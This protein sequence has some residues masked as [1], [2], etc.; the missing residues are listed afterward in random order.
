MKKEDNKKVRYSKKVVIFTSALFLG[1]LIFCLTRDYT[2]F[3]DVSIY[4]SALTITGGIMGTSVLW[5]MKKT[6]AEHVT[7]TQSLMYENVMKMRLEYN[8]QM[9]ELKKQ[10]KMED[11]EVEQIEM[12]SPMDDFSESV[13]SN[14]EANISQHMNEA[15]TSIEM[16]NY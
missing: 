15:T 6:Q 8:K 7:S 10:Y 12:E 4:A 1:T 5:Y 14:M 11:F 16:Q 9:M 3:V 13:M 2:S